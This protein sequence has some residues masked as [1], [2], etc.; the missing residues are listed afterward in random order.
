[1]LRLPFGVADARELQGGLIYHRAREAMDFGIEAG[2]YLI[3]LQPSA[4][5]D[6]Q[7]RMLYLLQE[8]S[9]L[10]VCRCTELGNG[11]AVFQSEGEPGVARI[12]ATP[13]SQLT[14]N[15]SALVGLLRCG[16]SLH[17]RP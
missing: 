5:V 6:P 12:V 17:I 7:L 13:A 11:H 3:A 9:G 10:C 8:E 14:R 4:R 16:A 1:M 2:D 15:F